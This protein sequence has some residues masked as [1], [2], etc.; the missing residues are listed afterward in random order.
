MVVLSVRMYTL[1]NNCIARIH[2]EQG[3]DVPWMHCLKVIDILDYFKV[4]VSPDVLQYLRSL[5]CQIYRT[6]GSLLKS[7]TWCCLLH[8]PQD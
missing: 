7:I 4:D 1:L 8:K 3:L 2:S 5:I 6:D